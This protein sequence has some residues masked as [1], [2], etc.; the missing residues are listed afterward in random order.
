MK[1]KKI[2][3]TIIIG[4]VSISTLILTGCEVDEAIPFLESLLNFLYLFSRIF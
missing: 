3:T 2:K 4:L 1:I